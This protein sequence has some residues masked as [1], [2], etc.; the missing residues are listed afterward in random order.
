MERVICVQCGKYVDYEIK[1]IER[2]EIIKKKKGEIQRK[3]SIL[4]R[5][6]RAGMG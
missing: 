2:I 1:E 5:M 4:Q 6:W 3:D